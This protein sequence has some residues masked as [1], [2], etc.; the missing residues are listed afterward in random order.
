L[1]ITLLPDT[2]EA[3]VGDEA[4]SL[5]LREFQILSLFLANPKQ[6]FTRAQIYEHAWGSSYL[7]GGNRTGSDDKTVNVHISNLR[8]KLEKSQHNHIKTVWGIGVR[9]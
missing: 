9:L 5:T 8:A 6:V 3:L 1:D 4:I 2:Y 7:D